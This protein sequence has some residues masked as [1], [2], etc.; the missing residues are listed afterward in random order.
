M[1]LTLRTMLA[2]MDEILEAEDAQDLSKKIEE[3]DFAGNLMVRIRDVTR[4]LRLGAPNVG[5]RGAM[6]DPNTVAEY[7]DN[8]LPGDR[9]PDFEKVC[10]ESDVHLAEVASCHQVLTMVLGEPAEIDA[11][12]RQRMYQLPAIVAAQAKAPPEPPQPAAE[13]HGGDGAASGVKTAPPPRPSHA[14]V[15]DYLREPQ[16]ARRRFWPVATAL[17]LAGF[18]TV[19]VLAALGQFAPGKPL[20]T[21]LGITEPEEVAAGPDGPEGKPSEGEAASPTETPGAELKQPEGVKPAKPDQESPKP[22][23]KAPVPEDVVPAKPET[24]PLPPDPSALAKPG[25][26]P[27]PELPTP[28]AE[29]PGP[30]KPDTVDVIAKPGMEKPGETVVESPAAKPPEPAPAP[31]EL[32]GRL[33]SDREVLL[34]FD[35]KEAAWMRVP[36]Q[37][38]IS[39]GH[40]L[41]ALPTF[42]PIIGLSAG[43]TVQLV[44]GTQVD[45]LPS[46]A[47]GL[48]GLQIVFGRTLLSTVGKAGTQLRLQAGSMAGTLTFVDPDSTAAV[49]VSRRHAPGSDPETQ[50]DPVRIDIYARNGRVGWTAADGSQ[51]VVVNAPGLL[52]LEAGVAV[53]PAVVEKLPEWI[54]SE[55]AS[56]L[57]RRASPE[58]AQAI[59]VE[60]PVRIG[61]LELLDHRQREV[62]WLAARCLGYTG[63]YQLMVAGLNNPEERLVWS[64]FIDQF[65]EAVL[66]GPA[67][68]AAVRQTMERQFGQEG[69]ALYRM[70]LGYTDD[71]LKA[72]DAAKLVGYLDHKELAFRVLAFWNLKNITGLGLFYQP[73]ATEAKRKQ[74]V[75]KWHERLASGGIVRGKEAGTPAKPPEAGPAEKPAPHAPPAAKPAVPEVPPAPPS[76]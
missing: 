71:G 56:P 65:Q 53:P 67:S 42:R 48:P 30:S 17:F 54:H 58:L 52:T 32:L 75:A 12:A 68:A 43:T 59:P 21:L 41:L 72:Q 49:S 47:E 23:E 74:S 20:A 16:V 39:S 8:T 15:P 11:D 73:E 69:S 19:V 31:A 62:R 25:E 76:P 3:S 38:S 29:K 50:L 63:E 26:K 40:E 61:L 6:F 9:V 37:G 14:A 1:R 4:R 18:L 34:R 55:T 28:P 35:P 33:L 27:A 66:R 22:A 46:G 60:R 51:P 70:L 10:L 36:A 45:L 24:P 2:Y 64:D 44:G 7:L 13:P 5:E 57:D